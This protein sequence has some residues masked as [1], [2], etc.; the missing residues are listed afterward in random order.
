MWLTNRLMDDTP[1]TTA[2]DAFM[3]QIASPSAPLIVVSN[4]IG[5]GIVPQHA[6]SREFREVHGRLNIALAAQAD[7]VVQVVAGLPNVL[8]GTLP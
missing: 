7:L 6:L 3:H 5:Q 2:T 1:L 8:K 4:E